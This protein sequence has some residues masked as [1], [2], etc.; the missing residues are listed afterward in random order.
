MTSTGLLARLSA[1]PPPRYPL[2]RYHGVLAPRSAWRRES[3]R[4]HRQVRRSSAS[5]QQTVAAHLRVADA[6]NPW[7]SGGRSAPRPTRVRTQ[8]RGAPPR[9]PTA[10]VV[11]SILACRQQQP[12][13][14]RLPSRTIVVGLPMSSFSPRT[15]LASAIGRAFSVGCST[16]RLHGFRGRSFCAA[17]STIDILD[18][19]KCHGRLRVVA[20]IVDERDARR[21]LERLGVWS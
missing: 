5:W 17:R 13:L 8:N 14:R 6:I 3:S 9:P 10:R 7:G 4:E 19:A 11:R 15:L 18:C 21:I 12:S 16:R 1:L 2:T 20:A